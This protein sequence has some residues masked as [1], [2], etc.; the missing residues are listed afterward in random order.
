V[1]P[2]DAQ[3]HRSDR[4]SQHWWEIE[5]KIREDLSR[6]IDMQWLQTA[7]G[8]S[9]RSIGRACKL[10]TGM[11][12]MKRVKEL[13]LSY[14]RGLVQ[15]SQRSMTEIALEVGYRR[16][17]ELSRDYRHRFGVTPRQD[18]STEPEY[19]TQHIPPESR[20]EES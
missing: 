3:W 17:Q 15:Y 6:A 9:E 20:S 13:R 8:C 14:A 16:V 4:Q 2:L 5:A 1:L 12:P 7:G 10:A 19:K 18:R 11:P